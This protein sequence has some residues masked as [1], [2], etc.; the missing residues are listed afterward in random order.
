M[1]D[2]TPTL[3]KVAALCREKGWPGIEEGTSYGTPAL[4]VKGKMLVRVREPGILVVPC[5]LDEK[6]MLMLVAPEIYFQT[7]HYEGWP[8]VLIRM[9][10]IDLDELAEHLEKVWRSLATKKMLADFDAKTH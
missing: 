10:N 5:D 2:F 1:D 4:K 7:K 9:D 3:E 8:A 6:E